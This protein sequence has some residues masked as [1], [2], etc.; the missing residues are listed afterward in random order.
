MITIARYHPNAVIYELPF[1][2][3][4][5]PAKVA[6][7]FGVLYVAPVLTGVN[8]L[9]EDESLWTAHYF[10]LRKHNGSLQTVQW[11]SVGAISESIAFQVGRILNHVGFNTRLAAAE[12]H[13]FS[14]PSA[15]PEILKI[16]WPI[17]YDLYAA[18]VAKQH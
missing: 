16:R 5:L 13:H 11:E 18:V 7:D 12:F 14:K 2:V 15:N 6:E 4:P 3:I 9:K 8:T 1:D 10:Q 17:N